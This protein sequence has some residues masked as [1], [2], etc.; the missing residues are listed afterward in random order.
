MRLRKNRDR[1]VIATK[2]GSGEGGKP[3][4]SSRKHILE[5][6][7][8]SLKRLNTDYVDLYYT[9]YDDG[10]TPVGETL[11][12]YDEL[13]KA[14]KVRYIAASNITPER[15]IESLEFSEINNLPKY[16]ALQPLYNLVERDF[17][18]NNFESVA[19]NFDLTVF[20]Y[21][22]LAAG[23]LTGKY[24]SETDFGKS[25]RG[26]GATKY[27]NPKNLSLLDLLDDI[28]N[29]HYTVPAA[30][31][32]AWLMSRPNIGAPV[33]SAT[34]LEQLNQILSAVNLE[35]SSEELEF[36]DKI[37]KP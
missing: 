17:Y 15:L 36:I 14:G 26:V 28:A 30:V 16:R 21:Y 9:H 31:A 27:L 37:S 2:T 22:G 23:F 5:A 19:Q 1:I 6:I 11:S 24:R 33:A 20:P 8:K 32:L 34:S 18:E 29:R 25:V 4:N 10:I 13:I 3:K 12:A 7:D 35:L